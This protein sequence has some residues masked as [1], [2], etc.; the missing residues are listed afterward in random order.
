[1]RVEAT[2]DLR[3]VRTALILSGVTF[4]AATFYSDLPA[5]LMGIAGCLSCGSMLE[6]NYRRGVYP[7]RAPEMIE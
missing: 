7:P 3:V 2:F 4:I 6:D 1:M 5:A